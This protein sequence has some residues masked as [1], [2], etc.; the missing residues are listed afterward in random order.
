MLSS[1]LKPIVRNFAGFYITV[2]GYALASDIN[3]RLIIATFMNFELFY[4]FGFGFGI[5]SNRFKAREYKFAE[6]GF[7]IWWWSNE[8][9]L[10][11]MKKSTDGRTVDG[12]GK[13]PN[14]PN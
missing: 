6:W 3:F 10:Y 1:G 7:V 11:G 9:I 5:F 2:L 4:L 13:K 12:P 8:L 14:F